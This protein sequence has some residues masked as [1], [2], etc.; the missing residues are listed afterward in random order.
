MP[1]QLVDRSANYE[2]GAASTPPPRWRD[3]KKVFWLIGIAA[4]G[5]A[6][7]SWL[8]VRYIGPAGVW[9]WTGA[10]VAFGLM[11]LLDYLVG[12]NS[13][14]P[15][16]S[17]LEG[18]ENDPFYRWAT[19]LFLPIQYLSL[20][21]SCWLWAGGGWLTMHFPDRVGLMVTT[22]I[23]GGAA[24]NAAHDLGHKRAKLEKRLSKIALAQTCY[25]QFYVE[26]NRG[27]HVRVA[28]PEDP[29]S[30]R[31]GESLYRFIPRAVTGSLRSAWNLEAKRLARI[32]RSRWSYQNDILQAWLLSAV[33]YVV[34]AIWFGPVVVPWL[35]GQAVV[36]ICLLETVNYL[37]HYGLRRRKTAE[38]RYERVSAAHSWN[39]NT[40]VAS[41]ILFHLQRHSDHHANPL[42]RYQ[43][44]RHSDE[45]P[46]LPA[47]Y[48][49]M[50]VIAMI[51]PLWRRIM[52]KRVLRHYGGDV[53]LA[54]L[55]PRKEEQL[56]RRYGRQ[57]PQLTPDVPVTTTPST[58]LGPASLAV[59][60]SRVTP[61]CRAYFRPRRPAH[62][63]IDRKMFAAR[64]RPQRAQALPP[65]RSVV[66][67]RTRDAF[68]HWGV[69][70]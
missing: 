17:A 65:G 43:A 52:D 1:T 38:G 46:Q 51:P 70:Y 21:F 68:R 37:E 67:P 26:H 31:M 2:T 39:S 50:I 63:G 18:L 25:G 8:C 60:T 24:I 20:A 57:L 54:A 16:D 6:G 44:L 35:F 33:L 61:A 59:W 10:I 14:N 36:G 41:L 11:P 47:G 9:W 3:P 66:R 15:P 27:H 22:G 42:R 32:N 13:D 4:P 34:L 64:L 23:F 7:L 12:P 48:G 69:G 40:V 56:L 5:L 30:S 49:S 29:A 55:C 62:W 58:A 28:T 19:Y 45:A 53:R